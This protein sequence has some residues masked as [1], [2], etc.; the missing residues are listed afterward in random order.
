MSHKPTLVFAVCHPDDE[1]LWVGGLLQGLAKSGLAR[2]LVVCLSGRDPGSPRPAEF[3]AA[4]AAAGYERGVVVGFPLRKATEPLPP[5]G[6]TLEEGLAELA[7]TREEVDLLVT[8][9]PH[10]DEHMHPHHVQAHRELKAWA[11]HASIPFSFFSTVPLPGIRHVPALGHVRRAGGLH[12][13]MLARC[14]GRHSPHTY[15][16]FAFDPDAKRAQLN[17]YRSVDLAE[18]ERGYA[19]FTSPVEGLYLAH[20]AAAEAFRPIIEALEVVGPEDQF[21]ALARPSARSLTQAAR[22]GRVTS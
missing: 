8:H 16:Q 9:P 17:C 21:A 5:T 13:T 12:L 2:C 11:A 7:L 14:R 18:H 10:G 4:R 15:V 19:S 22:V 6:P 1:A 3:E 20:A